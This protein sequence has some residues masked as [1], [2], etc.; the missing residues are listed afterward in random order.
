MESSASRQLKEVDMFIYQ[1]FARDGHPKMLEFKSTSQDMLMVDFPKEWKP[2][3]AISILQPSSLLSETPAK[4]GET[5]ISR[6]LIIIWSQLS[7]PQMFVLAISFIYT[8]IGTSC[9]ELLL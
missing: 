6:P 5:V 9:E 2:M 4:Y 7:L 3:C 1:T 8:K